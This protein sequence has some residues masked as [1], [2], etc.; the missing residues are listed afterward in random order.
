MQVNK[1]LMTTIGLKEH[2]QRNLRYFIDLVTQEARAG[3]RVEASRGYLGMLWW[4]IEPTIYMGIFYLVF[5]RLFKRGDENYVLFLLTGLIV[6]KWFYAT[7]N[8]GSNS[9]MA[10]ANL[11]NLVYLPK[12]IFP[13]TS[14]TINT[15]KFL[16]IMIIFLIF[17]QFSSITPSLTWF[18]L[19][20][21]ILTQLLLIIGMASLLAAIMPFFPD[22]KV[23]MDN[24]LLMILFISGIFFDIS[25]FPASTQQLLYLNP[26]ATLIN[27]Y[28]NLLLRSLKPDLSQILY[29][30]LISFSV[31]VIAVWLLYC[32]DRIYPKIIH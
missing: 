28:R 31:L 13:L 23:I 15:F 3:L 14:I 5:A 6:W 25:K 12:I 10:N 29:V 7:I 30:I 27:M 32:Y 8:S 22:L 16:V 19:P 20:L 11:M 1:N 17:L 24:I 9:L 26:I 2:P 18:Y 4:V 21:L